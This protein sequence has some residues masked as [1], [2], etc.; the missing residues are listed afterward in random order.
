[1]LP[2]D[3]DIT[4]KTR[5]AT[6]AFL[7]FDAFPVYLFCCFAEGITALNDLLRKQPLTHIMTPSLM[8]IYYFNLNP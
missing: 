1:M 3:R 2:A 4:G 6:T 7:R 5:N 8:N